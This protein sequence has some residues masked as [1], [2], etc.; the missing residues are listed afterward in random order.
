MGAI[1]RPVLV[2]AG[3]GRETKSNLEW[4]ISFK[5]PCVFQIILGT[6][7]FMYMYFSSTNICT[8]LLIIGNS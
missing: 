7:L 4:P 1:V 5:K 8:Q 6:L 2:D 3:R